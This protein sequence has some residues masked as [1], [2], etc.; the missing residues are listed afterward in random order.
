MCRNSASCSL[1]GEDPCAWSKTALLPPPPWLDEQ[2]LIFQTAVQKAA[3]GNRTEAI[4]IL[5][6]MRNDD[7]RTWFVEHGQVSGRIRADK[8]GHPTPKGF[9]GKLDPRRL[10]EKYAAEVYKRDSYRCRYCGI[11]LVTKQVLQA[12]ENAVGKSAFIYRKNLAGRK[13]NAER[14]GV[15]S[16]FNIVADH[17]VPHSWGGRTEPSNLV[18][19]CPSCNYGKKKY[20]ISQIGLDDPCD[21]DP[22]NDDWDGLMSLLA[23]LKLHAMAKD[24]HPEKTL[25]HANE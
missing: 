11:R 1:L 8:L 10:P 18:S 14:H 25:A 4:A 3:T 22:V 7:M 12:F 13:S 2:L 5:R 16:A 15:T 20:T 23:G 21:R 19:A 6:T 24:S 9:E 17:V